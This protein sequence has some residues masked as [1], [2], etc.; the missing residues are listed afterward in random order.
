MMFAR[1][2]FGIALGSSIARTADVS[3][4]PILIPEVLGAA[5]A[6][7]RFIVFRATV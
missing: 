3:P 2:S 6:P 7:G 1:A 4:E 5:L